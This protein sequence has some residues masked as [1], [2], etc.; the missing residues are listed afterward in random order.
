MKIES[1]NLILILII[2]GVIG[3]L[4]YLYAKFV[5]AQPQDSI[6]M[7]NGDVGS[8]KSS[9]GLYMTFQS[10]AKKRRKVKI[11]N[12]LRKKFKSKKKQ[13]ETPYIYCN[14]PLYNIE[15]K[16]FTLDHLLRNKRFEYNSNI[17]L[18]ECS[19]IA[20]SM[21]AFNMGKDEARR[22]VND[23]LKLFCK[24]VRHETKGKGLVMLL[25]TQNPNDLALGG[26]RVLSTTNIILKWI[27][28]IPFVRPVK[29][30]QIK[31][32]LEGVN[33]VFNEDTRNDNSKWILVNKKV[34]KMYDS[35]CYEFLTRDR[36][37]D[38]EVHFIKVNR[39]NRNEKTMQPFIIPT[40]T[41]YKEIIESNKKLEEKQILINRA[42][43]KLIMEKQKKGEILNGEK[44]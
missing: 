18:N 9:T 31:I 1:N 3:V 39:R 27:N 2:I 30:R 20:D 13:L 15:Y 10:N 4:I 40:I 28:W 38:K 8:G 22:F 11:K 21:L 37:I 19:L 35:E 26:D 17:Y 44:K 6:T 43:E 24:L 42:K 16:E 12:W 34:F 7:I 29:L 41:Q 14:I 33:N 5:G 32:N 36:P 25:D 23:Q